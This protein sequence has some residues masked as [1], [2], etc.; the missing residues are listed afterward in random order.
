[1]IEAVD[2]SKRFAGRLGRES[3]LAL[4]GLCLAIYSEKHSI[5][6]MVGESG[7]GK[8]ALAR[9]LPGLAKPSGGEIP[10]RFAQSPP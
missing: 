6:A 2:V 9:L 5:I 4:A 10:A 8:T 3:T 7:S 1:L